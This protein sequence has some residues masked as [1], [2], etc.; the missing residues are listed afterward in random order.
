M[1]SIHKEA[2]TQLLQPQTAP[3]LSL[4]QPTHRGL[5]EKGQD[6][7]QFRN[8]VKT[9]EDSLLQ[10]Y[11][12]VETRGFLKPFHDLVKDPGFW[13]QTLP[14]LAVLA[15]PDQF[16]VFHLARPVDAF[17][18]VA[19]SFHV[20]PLWQFLQSTDRY[21]V[22]GLSLGKVRLFEGDRDVLHEVEL[23]PEVPRTIAE[24]LG[25]DRCSLEGVGLAHR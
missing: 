25:A 10:T 3:C 4:Y 12:A 24:A 22:L 19:D 18:G 1:T 11:S 13:N 8:L 21:Q 9:M 14:G 6:P 16:H 20:K 23:A 2:L 17:A 5:P 7:I 15:G